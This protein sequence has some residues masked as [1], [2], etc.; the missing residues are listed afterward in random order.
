MGSPAGD[1]EYSSGYAYVMSLL[2]PLLCIHRL[3]NKS[4]MHTVIWNTA[5][6]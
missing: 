5:V 6:T 4:T 1:I 3:I 2:S